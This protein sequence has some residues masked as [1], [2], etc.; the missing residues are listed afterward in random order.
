MRWLTAQ[1][2]PNHGPWEAQTKWLSDELP[3]THD[4]RATLHGSQGSH[5]QSITMAR[6]PAS[7]ELGDD[8]EQGTGMRPSAHHAAAAAV[9]QPLGASSAGSPEHHLPTTSNLVSP[10]GCARA[11][12]S[13]PTFHRPITAAATPSSS[14]PTYR[15]LSETPA[16]ETGESQ[17]STG[18]DRTPTLH[19]GMPQCPPKTDL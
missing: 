17:T 4:E 1:E 13:L 19:Q 9:R 7:V 16:S 15:W 2:E 18:G 10:A 6:A 12:S 5:A 11:T 8:I 3:L 14:R